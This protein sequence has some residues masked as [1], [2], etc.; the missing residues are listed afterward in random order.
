MQK[1][2]PALPGETLGFFD[3]PS[4]VSLPKFP[5]YNLIGAEE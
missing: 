4:I 1:Q 2:I 3:E 5:L